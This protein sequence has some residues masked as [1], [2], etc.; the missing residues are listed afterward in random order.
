[1]HRHFLRAALVAGLLF[2]FPSASQEVRKDVQELYQLCKHES[3]KD[4]CLGDIS[5]VAD[6]MLLTGVFLRAHGNGLK[7]EERDLL[8]DLS[9]CLKAATS[10][11]GV[12]QTFMHVA[13]IKQHCEPGDPMCRPR[14]RQALLHWAYDSRKI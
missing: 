5:G 1:M 10:F 7:E 2:P 8:A 13:Q 11:E 9:A 4:F 3:G 14:Q 12:V 6:H